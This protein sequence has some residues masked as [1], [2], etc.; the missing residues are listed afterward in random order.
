VTSSELEDGIDTMPARSLG[1]RLRDLRARAGLSQSELATAAG[2]SGSYISLIEMD[3]RV[4]REGTL[5]RLSRALHLSMA[6]VL[7]TPQA[8]PTVLERKLAVAQS[9]IDAGKPQAALRK[10]NSLLRRYAGAVGRDIEYRIKLARGT[11]RFQA[12]DADQ[13]LAELEDLLA[14]DTPAYLLGPVLR[15]L[16]GCYLSAG[17]LG[18]AIDLAERGLRHL[19]G[20]ERDRQPSASQ[21]PSADRPAMIAHVD[22]ATFLEIGAKQLSPF[23]ALASGR[24]AIDGDPAA[25]MRCSVLLGLVSTPSAGQAPKN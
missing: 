7:G 14:A 22:S 6:D 21:G 19:E 4:P 20:T 13:A 11:A 12:G 23:E 24:L 2:V 25:T 3:R 18:R 5:E 15:T 16:A 10:L 1:A 8:D 9:D 17:D